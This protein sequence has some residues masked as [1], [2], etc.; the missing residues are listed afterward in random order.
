LGKEGISQD[1]KKAKR[2]KAILI[3]ADEA[4]LQL[5]PVVRRTWAPRGKTPVLK[6][7]TRSHKKISAIGGIAT[8]ADGRKPRLLFRLHPG[9]NVGGAECVA[10]LEQLKLNFPRR[11][12]FVIWDGLRAHWSRKV[13]RWKAKHPRIHL[14]QL[15]PYAPELNPIEYAWGHLKYH[16]LANLAPESEEELFAH[17]KKAICKLRGRP[18]VLRSFLRH[19]PINFFAE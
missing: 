14:Y 10:F 9:K 5:S 19:A 2:L 15:P 11:Q 6:T 12:V 4:A 18:E 8:G 1:Q 17:A 3:F 16:Q 13:F 7:K